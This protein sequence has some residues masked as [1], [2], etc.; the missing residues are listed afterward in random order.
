[1]CSAASHVS[2]PGCP[3]APS[4]LP[5]ELSLGRPVPWDQPSPLLSSLAVSAIKRHVWL[6]L[7]GSEVAGLTQAEQP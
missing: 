2:L 6:T 5:R 3:P 1:M 7:G 4:S